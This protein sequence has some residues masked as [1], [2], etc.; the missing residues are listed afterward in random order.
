M[1]FDPNNYFDIW[2]IVTYELVG[3]SNLMIILG[4]IALSYFIARCQIPF[5]TGI[6]LLILYVAI[7]SI[8]TNNIGLWSLVI[9]AVGALFY[10]VMARMFRRN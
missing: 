3:S 7:V 5:Q 9:L 1:V 10:W 6:A 4:M 2:N 8:L